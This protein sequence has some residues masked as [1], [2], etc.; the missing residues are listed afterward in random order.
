MGTYRL[1]IT[2]KSPETGMLLLTVA[3]PV[4]WAMPYAPQDNILTYQADGGDFI[5]QAS[6]LPAGTGRQDTRF[7]FAYIDFEDPP[8][9]PEPATLALLGFGGLGALL[10]RRRSR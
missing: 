7:V 4:T 5:I 3:D 6:D 9:V 8:V 1:S 2:A 10:R